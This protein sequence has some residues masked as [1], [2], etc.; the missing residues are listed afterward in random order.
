MKLKINRA[1]AGYIIAGIV[2]LCL[3]LYLRFPGEALTDYVKAAAA[4]RYP[5]LLLSIDATKPA[6]PPG[7]AFENVTTSPDGRPEATLH[8]DSLRVRPGG[9][10]LLG[11]RLS[12]L[13]AAEGYGGEIRGRVD[14]SR[15][16]SVQGPLSAEA[17]IREIRIEKCAWL[18][19]T[20]ARQITG[21]LE[22]AVAN[23]QCNTL[24]C[25]VTPLG[26]ACHTGAAS[27]FENPDS[28]ERSFP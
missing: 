6:F 26:P 19:Q 1:I 20:L 16:F 21:K 7:M 17:K 5:Q 8:A 27:C 28:T 23:C 13:M 25:Q 9:I 18:R 10:S 14:F 2:M 12:L 11:G 4:A 15:P 22:G 3:F 24:L